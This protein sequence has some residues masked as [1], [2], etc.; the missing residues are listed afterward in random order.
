M[1]M[2]SPWDL[3]FGPAEESIPDANGESPRLSGFGA[4]HLGDFSGSIGKRAGESG[5]PPA[6]AAQPRA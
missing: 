6:R 2:L 3:S 1:D 4:R 5:D